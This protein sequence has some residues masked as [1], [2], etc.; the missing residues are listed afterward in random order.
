MDESSGDPR[1]DGALTRLA[2]LNATPLSG[3]PAIFE[4]VH[5]RLQEALTGETGTAEPGTGEAAE[6]SSGTGEASSGTGG[7]DDIGEAQP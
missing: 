3:H 7:W 5:R 1:V 4:D 6:A 2:G